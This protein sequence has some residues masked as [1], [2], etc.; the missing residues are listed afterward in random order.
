MCRYHVL[1]IHS[2]LDGH[3][4]CFHVLAFVNCAAMNIGLHVSFRIVVR[5]DICPRM[6]LL[7]HI[8]ATFFFF[9]FF[10]FLITQTFGCFPAVL[11]WTSQAL[12]PL[13]TLSSRRILPL[14]EGAATLCKKGALQ[15]AVSKSGQVHGYK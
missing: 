1:L 6:R 5:P 13:P 14:S 9:F 12:T 8:E 4:G 11:P 3:L 10:F 2:S 15:L 7:D